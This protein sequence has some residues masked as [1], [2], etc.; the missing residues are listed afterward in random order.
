MHQSLSVA[1]ASE[2]ILLPHLGQVLSSLKD[3]FLSSC[4]V[5][6]DVLL[7]LAPA[8]SCSSLL[9]DGTFRNRVLR[10]MFHTFHLVSPVWRAS[11]QLPL[12]CCTH[13]VFSAS[14]HRPNSSLGRGR[15]AFQRLRVTLKER[16]GRFYD[17]GDGEGF[18]VLR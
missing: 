3:L 11:S 1:R 13:K 18:K 4:V 7:A 10:V 8:V 12:L 2:S 16:L 6:P 5:Y 9:A 14:F 17:F 15:R